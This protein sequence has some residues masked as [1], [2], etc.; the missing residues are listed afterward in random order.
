MS[1]FPTEGM[2][3]THILVVK[4]M[5]GSR[6]FYK[7]VLG[8]SVYREYRSDSTV[9]NFQGTWIL[10]VIAGE[11]TADKPD[12]HFVSENNPDRVSHSFTIRV[13]DCQAA[14][15]ILN[16]RGATFITPPYDWGYEKRCFFYDPDHNL[17][18]I[19]EVLKQ[20]TEEV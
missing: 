16:S 2:E 3:L 5:E 17:F 1:E 7:E 14:Y 12:V 6:R 13:P 19:S 10:L 9:L 4:D 20:K 11:P 18:E 8:A 15:D